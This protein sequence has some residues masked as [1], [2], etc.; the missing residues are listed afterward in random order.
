MTSQQQPAPDALTALTRRLRT[1]ETNPRAEVAGGVPS[2]MFADLPPVGT[3]P[4][5]LLWVSNGRKPTEGAGLGTGVLAA[6][7]S[8]AWRRV[9]DYS[10][11]AV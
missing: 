1:L 10:T 3:V 6:D 8:V 11:V 9:G 4:G 2:V 7:D 5:R